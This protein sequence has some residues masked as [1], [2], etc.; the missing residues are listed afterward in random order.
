MLDST[1]SQPSNPAWQHKQPFTNTDRKHHRKCSPER[2]AIGQTPSHV[3][4]AQRPTFAAI[5]VRETPGA[6]K[7]VTFCPANQLPQ[8]SQ[9]LSLHQHKHWGHLIE[10]LLHHDFKG[11]SQEEL[12]LCMVNKRLIQVTE[13]VGLRPIRCC[14]KSYA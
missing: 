12:A 13:S 14:Q 10:N 6:E 8:S 4:E 2:V 11:I 1:A 9:D 7:A 3:T 5:A